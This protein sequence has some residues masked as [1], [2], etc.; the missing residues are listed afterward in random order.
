MYRGYDM[1]NGL[2]PRIY[3]DAQEIKRDIAII[4]DRIEEA[5]SMLDIRSLI[6][7]IL[8]SDNKDNP[9]IL[10]FDLEDAIKEAKSALE[11]L[12]SLNEELL[13]LEDEILEVRCRI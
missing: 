7:D 10:I 13:M 3:R 5:N 9:E 4:N 8:V 12:K 11:L 1:K 2:P 6:I